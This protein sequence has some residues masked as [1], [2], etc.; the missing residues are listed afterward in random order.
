MTILCCIMFGA[1]AAAQRSDSLR[2]LRAEEAWLHFLYYSHPGI[3]YNDTTIHFFTDTTDLHTLQPSYILIHIKRDVC[4]QVLFIYRDTTKCQPVVLAADKT[5]PAMLPQKNTFL[6]IHGN[7]Y[8]DVYYQSNI[9]TPFYERDIYQHTIRTYLDVT[10]K[11]QYPLRVNFST[12]FSNSGMFKDITGIGF[13][14]NPQQFKNTVKTRLQEYVIRQLSENKKLDSLK[15]V[16]D[17]KITAL[18]GLKNYFSSPDILQQLIEARERA[19][20]QKL[21]RQKDSALQKTV[22]NE[23]NNVKDSASSKMGISG[24][25]I[26]TASEIATT[27]YRT[28]LTKDKAAKTAFPYL[29]KLKNKFQADSLRSDSARKHNPDSV[30]HKLE[31]KY[32]ANRTKYDSLKAE[33]DTLQ[34]SYEKAVALYQTFRDKA[35]SNIAKA[36][37]PQAIQKELQALQ[38]PDTILPK[39]YKKLL[40]LRSIGIGRSIVDYS[41]LSAKNITINGLQIEYNPSFY[42]AVATGVIDYQ[43]RDYIV[44]TSATRPKQYLNILRIGRGMK[45][46]NITILTLFQGKKQVYNYISSGNGGAVSSPQP[47]YHIVGFTLEKRYQFD[48]HNYVIVEAGKS[49][50]PYFRRAVDKQGLVQSAFRF[51]DRNNEAYAVKFASFIPVTA[52]KINGMYKH[53]GADYQSFSYFTTSSTQNAWTI[54]IEQPFFK[55]KLNVMASLRKNDFSSPYLS[56]NYQSNTLFKS[57]QATLRIK[58][59]PVLSAGYFPTAQLI[60]VNNDLY[61]EN[62]YYTFT[63]TASHSY[64]Y[65][66]HQMNTL[67][68]YVQ[69]YNKQPD[70]G[71]VYFNTKNIMLSQYMYFSRFTL[72]LN[73]TKAIST[74]YTL[75]T[76]GTNI[77]FKIKEWLQLGGGL[78][79]NNQTIVNEEQVGYSMNTSIKVPKVG[80]FQF[81]A[82]KGFIPGINRQLVE[83]KVGRFT[84]IKN[85]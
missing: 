42:I 56:N 75:Y 67:L 25:D 48:Q 58:K 22:F 26:T 28:Y 51:S 27:D 19:F 46:G 2:K 81:F 16:L 80:T 79:Y 68:S 82:E 3:K 50:L 70:S 36:K 12:R 18:D 20:V 35:I 57:I 78:K 17:K 1:P 11:D 44:N 85:F 69:F 31:N 24:E 10:I 72:Q 74:D 47:D 55:R 60:K 83:N 29:E 53:T 52:T 73:A 9:D 39:G 45:D 21:K 23:I 77:Q 66:G 49:S 40:A 64:R 14:F 6:K 41:E 76:T 63:G 65:K 84:F 62:Q 15:A 8:Y 30:L 7:I 54:K 61:M 59:W 43:F 34:Q 33:V 38:I 32:A 5:A 4:K 71:F 37:D 13:Q